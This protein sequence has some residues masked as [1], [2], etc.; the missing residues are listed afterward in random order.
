MLR[1]PSQE[2]SLQPLRAQPSDGIT[3]ECSPGGWKSAR[4]SQVKILQSKLE[5]C[6][7]PVSGAEFEFAL[8]EALCD[9]CTYTLIMDV[10]S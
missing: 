9:T 6:C 2:A 8:T 10:K 5:H 4:H 3:P 7:P 1:P